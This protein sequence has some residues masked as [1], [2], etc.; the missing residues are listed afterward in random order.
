VLGR[1]ENLSVGELA[2]N[3]Y[4]EKFEKL[5]PRQYVDLIRSLAAQRNYFV[6]ARRKDTSSLGR[7][8]G[9]E[10]ARK[11]LVARIACAKEDCVEKLE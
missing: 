3:S 8:S 6:A 4:V 1:L 10:S 11:T 5:F 9:G 2:P 7:A